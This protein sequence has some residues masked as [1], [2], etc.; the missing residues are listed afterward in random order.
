MNYLAQSLSLFDGPTLHVETTPA[1]KYLKQQ[2]RPVSEI[3]HPTGW[4]VLKW[5]C[6]CH[7]NVFTFPGGDEIA[8]DQYPPRGP[9]SLHICDACVA[10]S[11]L[12][13][14]E[15]RSQAGYSPLRKMRPL[16]D[17][18]APWG[19]G[20]YRVDTGELVSANWDSSG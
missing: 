14:V 6:G 2:T 3:D 18:S 7:V 9:I 12:I 10:A 13:E 5:D 11:P 16:L 15:I 20:V 8:F 1:W 19:H 4:R 17:R